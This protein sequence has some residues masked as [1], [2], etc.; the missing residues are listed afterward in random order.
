A[1]R[2][3]HVQQLLSLPV[4]D[5]SILH[6]CA[7]PL[8]WRDVQH[9]AFRVRR[10]W[11]SAAFPL[12]C[13]WLPDVSALLLPVPLPDGA[14]PVRA[15]PVRRVAGQAL[16]AHVA[17]GRPPHGLYVPLPLSSLPAGAALLHR[18]FLRGQAFHRTDRR[19]CASP[20]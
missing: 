10:G 4:P 6:A 13:E 15:L 9:P 16:P 5:G 18:G 19:S 1:L 20:R 7:F 12:P 8:Q 17:G 3:G 14:I 2:G 11:S